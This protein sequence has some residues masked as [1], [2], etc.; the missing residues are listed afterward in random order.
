M[1]TEVELEVKLPETG[2]KQPYVLVR[3]IPDDPKQDY[4][5]QA[6]P[7]SAGNC[8]WISDPVYVGQETDPSGLPFRVCAIVTDET[9]SRGQRLHELPQGP[10][11]CIDVTRR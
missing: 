4:W 6:T 7:T 9:L 8:R 10:S 3:P 2:D 1:A 11:H 5:V